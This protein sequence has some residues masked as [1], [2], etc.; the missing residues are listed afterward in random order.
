MARRDS[1]HAKPLLAQNIRRMR[2]AKSW[3]QYDLTNEA[4]A[5]QAL[6]SSLEARDANPTLESLDKIAGAL[7]VLLAEK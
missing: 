6:I 2:R 3:S 4:G 7:G 5:Q 1:A